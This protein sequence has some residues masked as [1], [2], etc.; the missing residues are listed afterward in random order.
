LPHLFQQ[1]RRG[2]VANGADQTLPSAGVASLER[3]TEIR[4]NPPVTV[5]PAKSNGV[6]PGALNIL[7]TGAFLAELGQQE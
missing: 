4:L 1:L 6:S 3:P 5:S 2:R 7:T